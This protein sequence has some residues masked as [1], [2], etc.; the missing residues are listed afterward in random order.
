MRTLTDLVKV[1]QSLEGDERQ[2]AVEALQNVIVDSPSPSE[3]DPMPLVGAQK[4]LTPESLTVPPTPEAVVVAD[5]LLPDPA[6]APK[7]D[8]KPPGP[9]SLDA[10]LYDQL[11]PIEAPSILDSERTTREFSQREPPLPGRPAPPETIVKTADP[12]S[13]ATAKD[14]PSSL[15]ALY[16]NYRQSISKLDGLIIPPPPSDQPSADPDEKAIKV[17]FNSPDDMEVKEDI[18]MSKNQQLLT[19]AE[20]KFWESLA[21]SVSSIPPQPD[22]PIGPPATSEPIPSVPTPDSEQQPSPSSLEESLRLISDRSNIIAESYRLRRNAPTSETYSECRELLAAMNVPILE[23]SGPYEGEALAASLVIHGWADYVATE[24]TVRSYTS[25][26]CA[27]LPLWLPGS[28]LSKTMLTDT[29][30]IPIF[31][32]D[33]LVYEAPMLRNITSHKSSS[34]LTIISGPEVR[35]SLSLARSSYV[36]FALLLG[37]DFS[38]RIKNMGPTRALKFIQDYGS[39]EEILRNVEVGGVKKDGPQIAGGAEMLTTS[40][41][42]E[43]PKEKDK[44]KEK[45]KPK[46]RGGRAKKV[47]IVVKDEKEAR[48][49]AGVGKEGRRYHLAVEWGTYMEQ[50]R[51]ARKV[52][53]TLPPVPDELQVMLKALS[54]VDTVECAPPVEEIMPY[55]TGLSLDD[56]PQRASDLPERTEEDSMSTAQTDIDAAIAALPIGSDPGLSSSPYISSIPPEEPQSEVQPEIRE[57]TAPMVDGLRMWQ[58]YDEREVDKVL[59]KYGILRYKYLHFYGEDGPSGWDYYASLAGNYFSDDPQVL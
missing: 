43:E 48:A 55:E 10:P 59:S 25:P 27:L 50:V 3:I 17:G 52:F 7:G 57:P 23:A 4:E 56:G 37:T 46:G 1:C 22:A 34:P 35:S 19:L 44:E 20:G 49:K 58:T 6:V 24:D 26:P 13:P 39:I 8:E 31:I 51:A 54:A 5:G 47:P 40:E 12:A 28:P 36:D 38:R 30:R 41:G 33:V 14:I 15:A 32:Q 45:E 21:Q 29:W 18:V 9:P 11:T 2:E 53:E 42:G 16:Q